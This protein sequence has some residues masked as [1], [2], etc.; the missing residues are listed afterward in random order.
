MVSIA[1]H[2][3]CISCNA[4]ASVPGGD[5]NSVGPNTMANQD[6]NIRPN[7]KGLYEPMFEAVIELTELFCCILLQNS[8]CKINTT[9]S[10][11][12]AYLN[13]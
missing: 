10:Y 8:D 7:G 6:V 9:R 1:L 13:R 4:V 3:H 5:R 11:E 2:C 12:M